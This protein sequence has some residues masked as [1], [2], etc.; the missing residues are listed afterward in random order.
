MRVAKSISN[1]IFESCK[2]NSDE[3]S[4]RVS[5][6]AIIILIYAMTLYFISVGI[7]GLII[8]ELV[9][10]GTEFLVIYGSLLSHHLI[11]LGANKR[12]E[13]KVKTLATKNE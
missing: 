2:I 1:I 7:Y 11:L 5:A 9:L 8:G 10:V 6:Y 3:S 12:A 4:T 13:T